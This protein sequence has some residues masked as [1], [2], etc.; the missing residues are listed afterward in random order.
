M[1]DYIL[2]SPNPPRYVTLNS[3]HFRDKFELVFRDYSYHM[4]HG[5]GKEKQK[6]FLEDLLDSLK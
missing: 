6:K 4:Q 3:E 2:M 1:N 5:M